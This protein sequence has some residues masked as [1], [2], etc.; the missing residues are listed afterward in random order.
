M[1]VCPHFIDNIG[2][3]CGLAYLVGQCCKLELVGADVLLKPEGR[4]RTWISDEMATI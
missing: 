3:V 1:T 4:T 2:L